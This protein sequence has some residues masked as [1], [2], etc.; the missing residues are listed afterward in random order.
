M[1]L[2]FPGSWLEILVVSPDPRRTGR[3]RDAL[4]GETGTV[5]VASDAREMR[6]RLRGEA[7]GATIHPNAVVLDLRLPRADWPAIAGA[8][9]DARLTG[10][11]IALEWEDDEEVARDAVRGGGDGIAGPGDG[12]PGAGDGTAGSGDGRAGAGDGA[13]DTGGDPR[14]GGP[15]DLSRLIRRAIIEKRTQDERI[16]GA[17]ARTSAG[18]PSA[19]DAPETILGSGGPDGP[20]CHASVG[21]RR[22]HLTLRERTADGLL[23]GLSAL[24]TLSE[25]LGNGSAGGPPTGTASRT[26]FGGYPVSPNELVRRAVELRAAA[27][28]SRGVR[29]LEIDEEY[30]PA[31]SCDEQGLLAVLGVLIDSVLRLGRTGQDARVSVQLWRDDAVGFGV[32]CG[33][34]G[35]A[36]EHLPLVAD[37]FAAVAPILRAHGAT[38]TFTSSW[39]RWLG[40]SF[41]LPADLSRPDA[42][43]DW[44]EAP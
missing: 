24:A 35:I 30:A 37:A 12:P 36:E 44:V 42:A 34:A 28:G 9:V 13:P 10:P 20:G 38:L 22:L 16:A 26:S 15:G 31:I 41:T 7:G 25:R 3:Y 40:F 18:A 4:V 1:S 39:G 8:I 17:Q 27:A 5:V 6:A 19:A 23:A 43:A 2:H 14:F 21:P 32:S 29:L 33:G 11:V